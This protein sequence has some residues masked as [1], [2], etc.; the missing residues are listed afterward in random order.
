[1]PPPKVASANPPDKVSQYLETYLKPA[2]VQEPDAAGTDPQ[3]STIMM[4]IIDF[5]AAK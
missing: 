3:L 4:T 2:P 5:K 1:V